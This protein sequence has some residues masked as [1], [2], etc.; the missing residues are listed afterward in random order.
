M[1]AGHDTDVS[2]RLLAARELLAQGRA[3]EAQQ[4]I[5]GVLVFQDQLPG[6]EIVHSCGLLARLLALRGEGARARMMAALAVEAARYCSTGPHQAYAYLDK[7]HTLRT[8][9]DDD[10]ALACLRRAHALAPKEIR[11]HALRAAG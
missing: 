4:V 9:G 2:E 7:A 8:L 11:S 6:E 5:D 3:T 1:P 10:E